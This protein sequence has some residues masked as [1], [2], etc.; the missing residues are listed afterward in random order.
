MVA[1]RGRYDIANA[2]AC[3]P[4]RGQ[5]S[6]RLFLCYQYARTI[7]LKDR[8]RM[9]TMFAEFQEILIADWQYDELETP[10]KVG[11]FLSGW[12]GTCI[13]KTWW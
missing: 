9:R 5:K 4:D 10:L 7:W 6:V 2:H 12:A 1:I 13:G 8:M 3:G 11:A